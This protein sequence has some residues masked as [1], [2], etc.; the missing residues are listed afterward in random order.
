MRHMW[1]G[2]DAHRLAADRE[3]GLA[4]EHQSH[5][6]VRMAVL[7][8]DRVRLHL[9]QRQHHLLAAGRVDVDAR[10]NAV[11]HT[12]LFIDE[13]AEHLEYPLRSSKFNAQADKCSP[14]KSRVRESYCEQFDRADA[15]SASLARQVFARR[16]S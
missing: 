7:L 3:V 11:V 6:L 8:D 10:E 2:R 15:A 1:P 16:A 13:V 12:V 4:F 14:A 5:L 9:H